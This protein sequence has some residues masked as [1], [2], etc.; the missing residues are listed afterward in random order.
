MHKAVKYASLK[1]LAIGQCLQRRMRMAASLACSQQ[2]GEAKP[3]RPAVTVA[4]VE[5]RSDSTFRIK[6][7]RPPRDWS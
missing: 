2:T 7:R 3:R 1:R 4:P 6:E 5:T